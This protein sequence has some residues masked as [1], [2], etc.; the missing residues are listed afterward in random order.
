[1]NG[2]YSDSVHRN[3]FDILQYVTSI[4]DKGFVDGVRSSTVRNLLHRH[5]L[6]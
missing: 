2:S 6:T 3:V 1:M 5:Q 4:N